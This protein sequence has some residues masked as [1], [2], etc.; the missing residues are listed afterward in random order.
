MKFM[1]IREKPGIDAFMSLTPDEKKK[2]ALE[3]LPYI[4]ENLFNQVI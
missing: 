4:R 2:L 3:L 1:D